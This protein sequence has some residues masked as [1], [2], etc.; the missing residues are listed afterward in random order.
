MARSIR[1]SAS[2]TDGEF[3][4]VQVTDRNGNYISSAYNA[5]GDIASITDPLGRVVNFNY[6]TS[7]YL[8]SITQTWT[9]NGQ[10]ETFPWARFSYGNVFVQPNFPGLWVQGPNNQTIPVLSSVTLPDDSR[11]T[12]DYTSW[13]QVY[14]ISMLAADGHTR[15]RTNY[16]LP[17]DSSTAQSECP[18]FTEQH[19]WAEYW[20]TADVVTSYSADPNGG[21]TR[22]TMPDGTVYVEYFAT[23]G[24]Q[25]GFERPFFHDG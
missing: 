21:W 16:N 18:R 14:Q 3:D 17:M 9:V 5:N 2:P 12:F 1:F 15:S 6:D 20:T 8:V 11:Y 13:G 24:W 7:N 25:T 10:P 22:E 23:S 4:C 19:Q